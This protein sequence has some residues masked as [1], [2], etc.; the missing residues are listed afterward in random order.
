MGNKSQHLRKASRSRQR[1]DQPSLDAGA[2]GGLC[3]CCWSEVLASHCP[4]PQALAGCPNQDRT[5]QA[6]TGEGLAEGSA[7]GVLDNLNWG[8]IQLGLVALAFGGIQVW[9]I[10]S[11]FW[12]RDLAR[13]QNGVEFHKTLEG[14]AVPAAV[15]P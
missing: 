7:A 13:P 1:G 15:P 9:W 12:R 6:G 8:Y 3:N 10:S 2:L 5:L 4:V 14:Y 11:V